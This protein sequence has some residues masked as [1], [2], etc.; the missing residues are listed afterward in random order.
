[1]I[2]GID[3]TVD[4]AFKHF[5]GRENTRPVLINVINS[6]LEG[7]G[8]RRIE[9]IELLNPFNPKEGPD[10]KPSIFDVKLVFDSRFLHLLSL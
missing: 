3:P 1:V 8:T 7:V 9:D 5:L 6:V 2:L 4:Y 10:D